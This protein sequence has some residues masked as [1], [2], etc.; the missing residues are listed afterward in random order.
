MENG[1]YS[2]RSLYE[3][4]SLLEK[5]KVHECWAKIDYQWT[6]KISGEEKEYVKYVPNAARWPGRSY[7]RGSGYYTPSAPPSPAPYLRETLL[8][9]H[10]SRRPSEKCDPEWIWLRSSGKG[11]GGPVEGSGRPDPR[12]VACRQSAARD[13]EAR[14]PAPSTPRSPRPPARSGPRVCSSKARRGRK[15]T[16]AASM[17]SR[18]FSWLLRLALALGIWTAGRGSDHR[19]PSQASVG[20]A[21]GAS[22]SLTVSALPALRPQHT[23][24]RGGSAPERSR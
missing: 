12:P 16:S 7:F 18:G 6:L 15:P 22:P 17:I 19:P 3:V 21:R 1:H 5:H 11:P 9:S 14:A 2:G 24:P 8:V 20:Q 23:T 13:P 4:L 10:A